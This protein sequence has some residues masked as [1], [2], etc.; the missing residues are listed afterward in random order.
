MGG[1]SGASK[2]CLSLKW[3]E[4]AGPLEPS[5][6]TKKFFMQNI[7]CSFHAYINLQFEMENG[8]ALLM[9]SGMDWWLS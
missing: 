1:R 8:V 2:S 9:V 3:V 5:K 6:T 7:F 4:K